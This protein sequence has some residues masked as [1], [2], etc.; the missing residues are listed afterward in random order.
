MKILKRILLIIF[1]F[2]FSF[3]NANFSVCFA[4]NNEREVIEIYSSN[5]FEDFYF[6]ENLYGESGKNYI[7][8]IMEDI[9]F[10]ITGTTFQNY[11]LKNDSG[12]LPDFV[13]EEVL[14]A[15][16]DGNNKT[17]SNLRLDYNENENKD[18]LT[19]F[20][21]L[22]GVYV[23]NLTIRDCCFISRHEASTF[24]MFA[25]DCIFENF[26]ILN[27]DLYSKETF[28][29]AKELYNCY[30]IN[31]NITVSAVASIKCFEFAKVV[32]SCGFT[33][34]T[35]ETENANEGE[36]EFY[37]NDEVNENWAEAE[38]VEGFGSLKDEIMPNDNEDGQGE[39]ESG[40]ENSQGSGHNDDESGQGGNGG[41]GDG[42]NDFPS[43]SGSGN[44]N[45]AEGENN[46]SESIQNDENLNDFE[47]KDAKENSSSKDNFNDFSA[48]VNQEESL[49]KTFKIIEITL[50]VSAFV[51]V[52][53]KFV[54]MLLTKR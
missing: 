48:N 5:F 13:K 41:V 21:S 37:S 33:I 17:I 16:I 1:I 46:D 8:K 30:F 23:K 47:K 3:F 32:D 53:I 6:N 10:D 40:G 36:N 18:L 29:F 22:E 52:L 11:R 45:V 39:I 42:E 54:I 27:F 7:I 12:L 44:E 14:T 19:F 2:T 38:V 24:C 31:L 20:Y 15:H 50:S 35:V 49:N 43:G 34:T 25:R 4:T 9:D 26:N 28:S 51:L